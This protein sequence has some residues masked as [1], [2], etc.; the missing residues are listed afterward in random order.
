[1]LCP[2]P[3]GWVIS[4]RAGALSAALLLL[5]A[6]A[7]APPAIRFVRKHVGLEGHSWPPSTASSIIR[8]EL[9]PAGDVI[10][11]AAPLSQ[12]APYPVPGAMLLAVN[13][14]VAAPT[15]GVAAIQN[16]SGL[17]ADAAAQ[18]GA[19]AAGIRPTE[20]KATAAAAGRHS[21]DVQVHVGRETAAAAATAEPPGVTTALSRTTE[22]AAQLVTETAVGSEAPVPAQAS[23]AGQPDRAQTSPPVPA[24]LPTVTRAAAVPPAGSHAEAFVARTG[25]ETD[26]AGAV[27]NHTASMHE[28]IGTSVSMLEADTASIALA[29]TAR[30]AA[31]LSAPSSQ[32]EQLEHAAAV[33]VAQPALEY[34]PEIKPLGAPNIP[35]GRTENQIASALQA[36]SA[37][38]KPLPFP[39]LEVAFQHRFKGED[40]EHAEEDPTPAAAAAAG[41]L[42]TSTVAANTAPILAAISQ[43]WRTPSAEAKRAAR[44]VGATTVERH[45][46]AA[47]DAPPAE[48]ER[49]RIFTEVKTAAASSTAEPQAQAVAIPTSPAG[50]ARAAAL[51]VPLVMARVASSAPVVGAGV[52]TTVPVVMTS[53]A[54]AAPG[55]TVAAKTGAAATTPAATVTTTAATT[56]AA[57]VTPNEASTTPAASSP[58]A[59]STDDD[60]AIGALKHGLL[61]G[62]LVVAVIACCAITYTYVRHTQSKPK[63]AAATRFSRADEQPRR[64]KEVGRRSSALPKRNFGNSLSVPLPSN[65]VEIKAPV[66]SAAPAP[67]E[68]PPQ[69]DEGGSSSL[70]V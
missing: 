32:W 18:P 57:T 10:R 2:R 60:S 43:D 44:V 51:V 62:V 33:E 65:Q 8:I 42:L 17:G 29:Q 55:P 1:M 20:G 61:I 46:V 7:E 34:K 69:A 41:V 66:A 48:R 5:G 52:A 37:E 6:D 49:A 21:Q 25:I 9:T 31:T 3:R 68:P 50:E 53:V 14:S 70:E 38:A 27:S 28:D 19:S 63:T 13:S 24:A 22:D 12:L 64:S 35:A 4:A 47:S 59:S 54:T 15:S 26:D 16:G 36:V 58:A 56:P 23:A 39:G 45:T 67:P 30:L 40:V 11:R